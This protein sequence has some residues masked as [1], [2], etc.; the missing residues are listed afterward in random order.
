MVKKIRKDVFEL[1]LFITTILIAIIYIVIYIRQNNNESINTYDKSLNNLNNLNL[2]NLNI[3]SEN[4]TNKKTVYLFYADWCRYSKIFLPIWNNV[5]QNYSNNNN[6][7]LKKINVDNGDKELILNY[8]ISKLPTVVD[9]NNNIFDISF[10]YP[11][12]DIEKELHNFINL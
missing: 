10:D 9:N 3:V 7:T 8:S 2:N 6:I 11:N 12:S 1:F 4:F 5:E